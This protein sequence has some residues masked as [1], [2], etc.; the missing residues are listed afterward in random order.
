MGPTT[1]RERVRDMAQ[2]YGNVPWA[3][4]FVWQASR[5][6]MVGA[7]ALTV[8]AGLMPLA[9]VYT[10]KLVID[11]VVD[12]VRAFRAGG[13]PDY[14]AIY[15]WVGVQIGLMF[16]QSLTRTLEGAMRSVHGRLL[17]RHIT[18]MVLGQAVRLDMAFYESPKFY[19]M[20]GKARR[21]AGHRPMDIV[22]LLMAMLRNV[23]T[24]VS[25]I[26]I[27]VRLHW[28]AAVA[29]LIT[30]IPP[31]IAG[32]YFG[33]TR[34]RLFGWQ[35]PDMRMM[36]Y[37][38]FA[39]TDRSM[40]KEIRIFGT[41]DYFLDKYRKIWRE[42]FERTTAITWSQARWNC[43]LRVPPLAVRAAIY[44]YVIRRVVTGL[45]TL[46]DL[47]LYYQAV[48]RT[49]SG[50]SS[51]LEGISSLHE[52]GLFLNNLQEFLA[53]EP[54]ID[55]KAGAG[56]A[57]PKPIQ[58]GIEFRGV[59]FRYPETERLVLQDVS[60]RLRPGERL[61][62]VGENG[63]GKTTLVK[64]LARLY[65]PTEG[66]ILLDGRDLRD[67][68]LADWWQ[69]VGIIFQ[70]FVRYQLSARENVGFGQVEWMDDPERILAAV[71]K[72]GAGPVVEQLPKGVETLLGRWFDGAVD[73]SIGQW[74]RI[75][76]SRAFMRES[77]QVLILDEPTA[78]LD[79][80]AEYEVYT[81][82]AKLAEGRTCVFISHRFSTVRMA[83]H[84]LV[85]DE[86]RVREQGDHASLLAANGIYARLFNMQADRY[87]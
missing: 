47:T 17:S 82:F 43:L 27:M 6:Y 86:G 70:D 73:L 63:A 22:Y 21:E 74:Q 53:L 78:A 25:M 11:R 24:L 60:F 69:Q 42:V 68:D 35:M 64:L 71:D 50:F 4:Q 26:A 66:Q 79:A 9:H 7:L 44:V 65:D 38:G 34:W 15:F 61:A 20:L 76:L 23:I 81:G 10:T 59:S 37:M 51:V 45:L 84:I 77:A 36:S 85:I 72:G 13:A 14:Q 54:K 58:E 18:E 56:A 83:N 80:R 57:A 1:L 5:L 32:F 28:L 29:I 30:V 46:G 40:A 48:E 16:V 2:A 55:A 39:L 3:F 75:A 62:L 19:D 87:R 52:H 8:L 31:T 67:Y 33:R 12:A 41:D 49:R